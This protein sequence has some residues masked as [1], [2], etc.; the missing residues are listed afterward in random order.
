[1]IMNSCCS[2]KTR[3]QL[4]EN[5]Y[6][7][8]IALSLLDYY[9]CSSISKS[10]SSCSNFTN[11]IFLFIFQFFQNF[12]GFSESALSSILFTFFYKYEKM[13]SGCFSFICV[14]HLVYVVFGTGQHRMKQNI[15]FQNVGKWF[16]CS[17]VNLRESP[18]IS[19]CMTLMSLANLI[20]VKLS[21]IK[22]HPFHGFST[23][24]SL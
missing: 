24:P 17:A 12:G 10:S 3:T 15:M 23:H 20:L 1:M 2:S 14:I 13:R 22:I 4:G 18:K 11:K 5:I 19:F 21:Q 16:Q 9:T 7:S 8:F 6:L